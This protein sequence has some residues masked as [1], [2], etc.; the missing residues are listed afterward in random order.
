MK[1][2]S[3]GRVHNLTDY[4]GPV[5]LKLRILDASDKSKVLAEREKTVEVKA[6][7][8]A[9][10]AFDAVTVPASAGNH[11]RTDRHRRHRIATP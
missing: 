3:V 9:E 11:H 5:T 2:A 4:A 10:A 1:S 6:N 7:S 8:G